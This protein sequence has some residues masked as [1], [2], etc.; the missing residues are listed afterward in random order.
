[1]KTKPQFRMIIFLILILVQCKKTE[2]IST[3]GSQ[4]SVAVSAMDSSSTFIDS[5]ATA[6]VDAAKDAVAA[7]ASSNNDFSEDYNT[8][9]GATKSGNRNPASEESYND[10]DASPAADFENNNNDFSEGYNDNITT[11]FSKD[12]EVSPPTIDVEKLYANTLIYAP[13]NMSKESEY[14]ILAM[15]NLNDI[16]KSI[17]IMSVKAQELNPTPISTNDI[18]TKENT[19]VTNKIKVTLKY[20]EEVFEEISSNDGLV[21]IL[22][23]NQKEISWNWTLKPKKCTSN[24]HLTFIFQSM[25]D[26]KVLF[27]EKKFVNV[28]ISVANTFRGYL[29]YLADEPK[30]TIPSIILPLITFFVGRFL[31]R[32]KEK[33]PEPE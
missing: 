12:N 22:D 19:P 9:N 32:K 24:A 10:V 30:Y 4:D 27:E 25:D 3:E 8:K 28:N 2:I 21:Q 13:T 14:T 31:R 11:G 18:K 7:T 29:Q 1:M 17:G 20:D 5:A 16:K 26:N 23:E 33:G 6:A 15:V